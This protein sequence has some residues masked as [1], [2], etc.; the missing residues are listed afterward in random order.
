MITDKMKRI[1]M[2]H[3]LGVVGTVNRDGTPNVSPKGTMLVIDDRTIIFGEI[4]SPRTLVNVRERPAMEINFVDVLARLCFRAK[5]KARIIPR[6]SDEF[7][8]LLPNFDRWEELV[9]KINNIICLEV[10]ESS[11]VSSPSY[12]IGRTEEELVADMKE[13]YVNL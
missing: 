7:S 8:T 6:S 12:D 9:E 1:V 13:Y 5:G 11:I 2:G 3:P 4:R 10:I